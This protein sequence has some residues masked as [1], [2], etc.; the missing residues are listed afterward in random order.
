MQVPGRGAAHC[1]AQ[2]AAANVMAR[3]LP[4]LSV[5]ANPDIVR[6]CEPFARR[7][8]AAETGVNDE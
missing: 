5:Y 2:A 7:A 6:V 4:M 8:G 1:G 3:I